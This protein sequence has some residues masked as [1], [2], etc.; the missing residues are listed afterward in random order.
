[1][2]TKELSERSINWLVRR[3]E[4]TKPVTIGSSTIMALN[5]NDVPDF[6]NPSANWAHGGPIIE[7]EMI[8]IGAHEPNEIEWVARDYWKEYQMTGPTPLIAAMRCY[9][10]SKMGYEIE[11][12]KELK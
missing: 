12:P 4:F 11:I 9:I 10:A 5:E 6:Y 2:L 8:E 1:M 3:I 7:R